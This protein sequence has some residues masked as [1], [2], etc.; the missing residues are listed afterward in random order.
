MEKSFLHR[1]KS[2]KKKYWEE[3]NIEPIN[4]EKLFDSFA[5]HK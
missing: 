2:V 4:W 1:A 5:E 3:I